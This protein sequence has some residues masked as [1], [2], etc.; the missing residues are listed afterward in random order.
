MNQTSSMYKRL[1][2]KDV[3]RTLE[4]RKV[5]LGRSLGQLRLM[6]LCDSYLAIDDAFMY[7]KYLRLAKENLRKL[8]W[9]YGVPDDFFR[10]KY[11]KRYI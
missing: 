3:L 11:L 5:P 4:S 10:V 8:K 7:R 2:Y 6:L 9:I 1:S